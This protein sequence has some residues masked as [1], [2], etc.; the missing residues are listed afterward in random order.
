MVV[1]LHGQY[2]DVVSPSEDNIALFLKSVCDAVLKG[3]TLGYARERSHYLTPLEIGSS[4]GLQSSFVEVF[5]DSP[6]VHYSECLHHSVSVALHESA[7]FPFEE[8]L[9]GFTVEGNVYP[10]RLVA[11]PPAGQGC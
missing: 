10:Y 11:T 6:L 8:P 9:R 1:V 4:Q 2:V 3:Y 7:S 5:L